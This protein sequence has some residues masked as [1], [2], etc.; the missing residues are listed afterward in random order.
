VDI[1]RYAVIPTHNRLPQLTSLLRQLDGQ[2]DFIFVIDNASDPPLAES[3]LRASMERAS[4]VLIHDDEQP[5]NLYRLWNV[6]FDAIAA[7]EESIPGHW[8]VAVFNDD[9]D[10]P[11][12]WYDYVAGAL[13]QSAAVIA[14]TYVAEGWGGH[15]PYLKTHIDANIT[16]RMCPW[17][18]VVRGEAGLRAD[19]TM[20]WWWGDTDFEWQAIQAGGVLLLPG[21]TVAN[22]LA[23]STTHG[24]LAEQAA[25]DGSTFARKWGVKPW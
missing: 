13:R 20:R 8:D 3:V 25:R 4:V 14:S 12:G 6:A 9:A 19:E 18:F 5:P 1:T 23:N 21:K 16:T 11:T 2:C 24:V 10:V 22:T 17:A 7:Y 15:M